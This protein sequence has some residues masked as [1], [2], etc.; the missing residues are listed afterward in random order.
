MTSEPF[1]NTAISPLAD[2]VATGDAAEVRRQLES[3]SNPET[4]GSDGASL[5]VWAIDRGLLDGAMALLEGGADPN[6]PDADGTTPVHAAAFADDPTLL[7][8]VLARGGDPN[9]RN[10]VTGATPLAASILNRNAEPMRILLE[11]G[12]DPDLAD[13]NQDVPLHVAARTNKGAA[14][15]L[16]LEHGASP[17][18]S[19]GRGASFQRHYF[20]YRRELLNERALAERR[21]IVAWLKQNGIPLEANVDAD[22]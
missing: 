15:L 2:A 12:A 21:Q 5:L 1:T 3:G 17:L 10:P 22:Y 13:R 16:L 6:H 18:A 4:P 7:R 11:A 8:A 20:N 14:I 9:V 19:N